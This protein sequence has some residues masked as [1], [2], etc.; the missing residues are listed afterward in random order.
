MRLLGSFYSALST[1][2]EANAGIGFQLVTSPS[3][4][5]WSAEK[6]IQAAGPGKHHPS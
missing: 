4:G 1:N 5:N 3:R 6:Y 2:V